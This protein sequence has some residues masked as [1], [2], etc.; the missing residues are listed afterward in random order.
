MDRFADSSHDLLVVD[1]AHRFINTAD[2]GADGRFDDLR[3][4]CA[5]TRYLLLLSATPILHRD[6]EVLALLHLLDPEQYAL[7]DI[8][9]FRRRVARRIPIGRLLLA[10]ERASSPVILRRQLQ[11]LGEELSDDADLQALLAEA[12]SAVGSEQRENWCAIATRVRILVAETWRL[13]RRLVRTQRSALLEEGEIQRLRKLSVPETA[14]AYSER[15]EAI[16]SLWAWMDELRT[17][18]AARAAR[19]QANAQK[20]MDRYIEL[21]QSAALMGPRFGELLNEM[22]GDPDWAF[23]CETLEQV[24]RASAEVSPSARLAALE[25]ALMESVEAQARWV[26]FCSDTDEVERVAGF[27][28]YS[29]PRTRVLTLSESNAGDAGPLLADFSTS[30][31]ST[32]LVVDRTAEEGLNLQA[33]DGL[34]LFDLPFEPLRLEQRI[35]RLDRLDRTRPL[36]AIAI[37]SIDDAA[38]TCLAFDRAWYEVLVSGLGLFE[39]SIADVPYLLERQ[40]EEMA[41]LAFERGPAALYEHVESLNSLLAVER[42]ET[43]ELAV[44]D[45]TSVAGVTN[46]NWWN[47]LEDADADEEQLASAFAGYVEQTLGLRLEAAAPGDRRGALGAFVLRRN[48]RRDVLL[49]AD[50]LLSLA[51]LVQVPYTF[52]RR[53]ATR[54]ASLELLRPGARLLDW[55]RELADWDDRGRAFV[56]W[57]RV[58]EWHDARVL[59][60]VNVLATIG[61]EREEDEFDEVGWASI[62]RMTANWF[63]PFRSEWFLHVDGAVAHDDEAALCLPPYD[64]REDLNLGGTRVPALLSV[65]PPDRWAELCQRWAAAALEQ[66]RNSLEFDQR[67]SQAR[68]DAIAWFAQRETRLRLREQRDIAGDIADE[69]A[70]LSKLRERV[71]QLLAQPRL[72]VDAIGVYVLSAEAPEL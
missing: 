29:F 60:R 10:L 22:R 38:D 21:A 39:D 59:A 4:L 34:V 12:P 32:L 65:V 30:S 9:G 42:R 45:G 71:D 51:D 68:S 43:A 13:H 3:A 57:R 36:R 25:A 8:D 54:D 20:L 16:P 6:A 69:R 66:V 50:R 46:S 56:M 28:G 7:D 24:L 18:A 14:H 33:A 64:R 35:G 1:E 62:R 70:M 19:V 40:M 67:L 31:G 53:R 49:P 5:S 72:T 47:E 48:K 55:L 26:V 17:A 37:L 44:I 2:G 63:A 52:S 23:A 58:P 41:H 27:L 15:S 61:D 11:L